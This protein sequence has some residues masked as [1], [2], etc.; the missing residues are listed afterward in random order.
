MLIIILLVFI[1]LALFDLPGLIRKKYWRELAVYSGLM[2]VA[3]V[4]SVL[5]LLNV[6]LPAVTTEIGNFIERVFFKKP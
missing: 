5:M 2:L 1:T 3:L 4:L 6:Q